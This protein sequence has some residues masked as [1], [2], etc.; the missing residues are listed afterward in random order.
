MPAAAQQDRFLEEQIPTFMSVFG[1]D[2]TMVDCDTVTLVNPKMPNVESKPVGMTNP[3]PQGPLPTDQ[4]DHRN[5]TSS[6]VSESTEPSPTMTLST[7]DSSPLTDGSPS[8]SPESPVNLVPLNNYPG[9]TFGAR[10]FN[11]PAM[12]PIPE[13]GPAM[14]RP[15]TS[16][17]PRRRN[18]KGLSIQPPSAVTTTSA[19]NG[20]EPSTPLFIKPMIPGMK[21]KPSLL[22]LKT[23]TTDLRPALEVPASPAMPPIRERRALKH[24]ASTPHILPTLRTTIPSNVDSN[25]YTNM[26]ERNESGLSEFL[27]PMKTG[28]RSSFDSSITE[29]ET[30]PI[31]TQLANCAEYEPYHES[32]NNEDQKSPSYPEGPIAIYGDNV[33]LYLEPTAA[34]AS[35]FDVVFNVAREVNNPFEMPPAKKQRTPDL[36]PVPDTAVT[37]CSFRTAFEYP[38]EDNLDTPTTPKANPLRMPEYIH[39]PWDHN[40]DIA[41]DLMELCEKIDNRTKEGKKVLI[42]CQQGASRSAS[43]I[44]AYGLYQNPELSVND[45]YYSAQAKS[46][47]ISPNMKLMYSLQDF[48]KEVSQ[49]KMPASSSYKPRNGRSPT[50]HKLTLSADAAEVS[51]KEPRTAPLP[52]E[53]YRSPDDADDSPTRPRGFSSPN[54]LTNSAISPGPASAPLTFSWTGIGETATPVTPV[55]AI[56]PMPTY[57]PP[58]PP[59]APAPA[60][61]GFMAIHP[62]EVPQRPKSGFGGRAEPAPFGFSNDGWVQPMQVEPRAR[63]SQGFRGLPFRA[64]QD[65]VPLSA[66]STLVDRTVTLPSSNFPDTGDLMSPRIEAMMN[67][68]LRGFTT[69]PDGGMRFMEAPPTPTAGLFSPR[70]GKFPKDPFA[71]FTRPAPVADPRSPPTRGEA[72][73]VRCI[74]DLI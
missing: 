45:A 47:W 57:L 27:R 31:K 69:G 29:E 65:D 22:S 33:F 7:T 8:S 48:Q 46:K 10:G 35:K 56:P 66:Q 24:S 26:L 53:D 70:E 55:L 25:G 49:K 17:A 58:P 11:P 21:R 71:T 43:L 23:N 59:P 14:I 3:A 12:L 41:P 67:N 54:P 32:V 52:G 50:K 63:S 6:E 34:E 28:T 13:S 37:D 15:M 44:I 61:N 1:L 64:M 20:L 72:S 2:A 5:S 73:I 4:H 19:S 42:H 9:T 18:M 36:S 62:H 40:T 51:L 30:S 16:P 60:N 39:I 74:D 68:P 38:P